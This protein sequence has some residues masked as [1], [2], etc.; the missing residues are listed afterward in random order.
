MSKLVL[1]IFILTALNASPVWWVL[2][3]FAYVA[4]IMLGLLLAVLD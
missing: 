4:D 3:G 1:A 2:F